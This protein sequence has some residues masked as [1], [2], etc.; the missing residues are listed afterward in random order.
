MTLQQT[1]KTFRNIV[2][3]RHHVT[4]WFVCQAVPE[5]ARIDLREADDERDSK[6]DLR[7]RVFDGELELSEREAAVREGLWRRV[8]EWRERIGASQ[9]R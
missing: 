6:A 1:E 2:D 4:C 8:Q 9:V 7:E 5:N 3:R